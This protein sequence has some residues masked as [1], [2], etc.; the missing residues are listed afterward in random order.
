M[1]HVGDGAGCL[2]SDSLGVGAA[3]AVHQS[4]LTF[5]RDNHV[6]GDAVPLP[7]AG[8]PQHSAAEAPVA[9]SAGHDGAVQAV[10]AHLVAQRGIAAGDLVRRE[11]LVHRIPVVRRTPHRIERPVLI[12]PITELFPGQRHV[13]SIMPR[14]SLL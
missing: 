11:L 9:W 1:A 6:T 7:V 4:W 12:E 3:H 8:Q 13:S 5:E 2:A 10:L 14:L